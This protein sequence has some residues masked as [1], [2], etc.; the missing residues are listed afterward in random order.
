MLAALDSFD[1]PIDMSETSATFGVE[2]TTL[3]DFVRHSF[4][5]P[6]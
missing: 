5:V 2:L 6:V 4:P 1:F 3:E